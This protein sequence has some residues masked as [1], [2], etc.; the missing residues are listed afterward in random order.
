M[1]CGVGPSPSTGE[2]TAWVCRW[3]W[4][5]VWAWEGPGLGW[6][7]PGG[8]SQG[9]VMPTD[10]RDPLSCVSVLTSALQG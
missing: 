9:L 8:H 10:S 2:G 5:W 7:L 1:V 3:M 6:D 4:V